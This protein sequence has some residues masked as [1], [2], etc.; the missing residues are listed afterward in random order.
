[1]KILFLA[2]EAAPFVK[3]GGLGDVAGSLP[4]ALAAL[5]HD[6][7][8][9]LPGY[10]A[11]D[12]AR[13]GFHSRARFGVRS[14]GGP[15]AAELWEAD[16]GRVPAYLV[17]GPPIP[18]DRLIYGGSIEEDA[19]K[20]VFF[21]L[22]ALAACREIR[23]KPDVVHA[24]DWHTGAAV[25]SLANSDGVDEFFRETATLFTIHNLPYIG[26]NAGRTLSQWDLPPTEGLRL[27]PDWARD[28]LLG[29]GI[30]TADVLSTVSPTYAR[31][32]RT[33][34]AGQ[35]LDGVLRARGDR[36]HGVL[37][38]IDVDAWDPASDP[39]LRARFDV[40]TLEKRKTNRAALQEEAGLEADER[41]LL[42]GMVSRLDSQKGFDIALPVLARWLDSGGQVV[43]LGSGDP[44]IEHSVT[45]LEL[46]WRGRASVRLRFDAPYS[47]LIYGGADAMLIPSKYEPCGLTQMIAMRYGAVPIA[48]RTGGLADTITDVSDAG[49]TGILFD[50]YDTGSLAHAL[51]RAVRVYAQPDR[52][53][54]LQHRGMTRDF[55]WNRSA[56]EYEALYGEALRFR[57][58][59]TRPGEKD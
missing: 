20:F 35:G 4:R 23:W 28:S 46:Q 6:V 49:G 54:E 2:A 31:E 27:L 21:S 44:T 24:N 14:T 17:T 58:G 56:M 25:Y 15:V 3:V 51:E 40:E 11:I 33:S 30:A 59:T 5:G 57:R 13:F 36:L 42:L 32:I 53:I 29:I 43:V 12:R 34:E 7:R 9:A 50:G 45:T 1:L 47:S 37:N 26:R 18:T 8:L 52:W 48:R 22:A 41:A 19:P 38:G 16:A 55:S 39:E 10:G